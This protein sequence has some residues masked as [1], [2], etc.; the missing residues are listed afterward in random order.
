M[1]P[2]RIALLI[3]ALGSV[4]AHAG[5]F[6]DDEARRQIIDLRVKS[7]ARFDQQAKGQ[8][9]L[10]NQIQ[11][12][13][14]EISRLRGQ[15]ETLNYELETAK[16]RQQDFYLDLDTRL[17]KFET[18]ESTNAAVN[19]ENGAN[20]KPASDPA[21]E[22]QEYEAALNQF[23]A[24]KYKEAAAGFGA[25]VQKYPASSLAPNAQ[26]W[27]GNAWYAQRD[28]KRAIEAQSVVTTKYADSAKAPDA[29]LA[30]ATCQQELGNPTGTKRSLETVIA[31]YP[32]AP[33]AETARERLKKK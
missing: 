25:F 5:V 11:R 13:A 29:W 32:T 16:K 14:D 3:A 22:G 33:A 15:I 7:E 24:G 4:Q 23:K 9:D 20:S 28:C 31:K 6:D 19:P 18:A 21:K 17:R 12:Q 26:Y 30:I 27:L 10:A 8:L 2:V 1:R